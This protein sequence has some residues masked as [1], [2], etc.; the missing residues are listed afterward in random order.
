[1]A[2]DDREVPAFRTG[3]FA[4]AAV[5]AL[6]MAALW[7]YFWRSP[8]RKVV[9][10]LGAEY[11]LLLPAAIYALRPVGRRVVASLPSMPRGA[12]MAGFLALALTASWMESHGELIPDGSFISFRPGS[13]TQG[14]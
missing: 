7:A 1:M 5:A 4:I 14:I 9:L 8:S 6:L 11:S 10:F 12:F 3:R 2:G 13:S